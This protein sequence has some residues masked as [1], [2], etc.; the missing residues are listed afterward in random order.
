MTRHRRLGCLDL[1]NAQQKGCT[2]RRIL[3]TAAT[4]GFLC[5]SGLAPAQTAPTNPGF[6]LNRYE[7]SAAG[8]WSFWVDHPWYSSM[9]SFA[10]GLTL[11]YGHNPLVFGYRD[12]NGGF[13]YDS[14]IV[15]HQLLGH[16]DLAG[17]FLDRILVTAT[18]PITLLE[19]GDG[20]SGVT[21]VSTAAVGDLRVGARVRLFGQP[22]AEAVSMSL[23]ADVWI[24]IN[25]LSGNPF[26]PQVG[27]SSLRIMPKLMLGGLSHS[28]MW[29]VTGAFLYRP[30]ASLGNLS[31][32][33]GNTVG[34]SIQLGASLKYAHVGLGLAVGPEAILNT[35]ISNGNAFKTEFTSIE[36]L[37]GA[38]YSI[39][40]TFQVGIGA[41]LG[42]LREP[43][44]PDVRGLLRLAYAPMGSLKPKDSDGDGVPDHQ[45]ACRDEAG[46]A[47]TDPMKHGCPRPPVDTDGD[48]LVDPLDLC[49]TEPA[50]T[51]PDLN[52]KGCPRRDLDK[53]GFFDDED[54][55]VDEAAG[56][57]ADPDKKGCPLRDKDGDGVFDPQDLC[58]DVSAGAHPDPNKKGCPDS[59]TDSDGVYDAQ[60]QCRDLSAGMFPDTAKP[61]CP[62]PDRDRDLVPDPVDACPDKAGAPS[63]DPKKHGC[64]GLVE[65][66]DGRIVILQQVFFATGK[67][68]ILK[69]S[70]KVLDAVASVLKSTPQ[71]KQVGIEGHTDDKGQPD[72]NR[73][74]SDRR[75]KSVLQYLVSHGVEASRLQAKGF[76][77]DRPVADNKTA[78]GRSLNRRTDFQI[79][80][81]PQPKAA[82]APSAAQA[83]TEKPAGT[84]KTSRKKKAT[85]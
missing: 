35:V 38:H 84:A 2:L 60:D 59:D 51:N 13:T 26:P 6:Q 9:R 55:C 76:G 83:P 70:F 68:T 82:P 1:D 65:T 75:A 37:L 42:L 66:R 46:E 67:D 4:L 25:S 79:I 50:G 44:T 23:G 81:P 40:R 3:Q 28:L 31:M 72:M 53:D 58:V 54:L 63:T 32:G 16:V 17:S 11:N 47:N 36:L 69:K 48:G 64:P 57:R 43:G 19:R 29:S 73:D 15:R 14:S 45:D 10:A 52:K 12:A 33:A 7:P 74:L 22:Y 27:E 21:L 56:N 34:P 49:P 30:E 80:D 24:P 71:I 61:G 62:L 78:K 8:E 85:K 20:G 18:L 41:G 77:P 5:L 39:A